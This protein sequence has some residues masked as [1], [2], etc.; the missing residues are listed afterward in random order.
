M[1]SRGHKRFC[2]I[3][4]SETAFS[5]SCVL[6]NE[7]GLVH[8]EFGHGSRDSSQ[9]Q[10]RLTGAKFEKI[11]RDVFGKIDKQVVFSP[12]MRA[13]HLG[14]RNDGDGPAIDSSG[15]GFW[16]GD[17]VVIG[18]GDGVESVLCTRFDEG[19]EREFTVG[20]VGVEV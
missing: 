2:E 11:S 17:E 7:K 19:I 18:D 4:T 13:R 10:S 15:V 14:A 6:V 8:V 9:P 16:N 20:S 12:L 5:E 1:L 3:K